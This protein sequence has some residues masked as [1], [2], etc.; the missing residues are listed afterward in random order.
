MK[1]VKY[2]F[3]IIIIAVVLVYGSIYRVNQTDQA[4]VLE[5]GKFSKVVNNI[6]K[7]EPGLHFKRPFFLQDVYTYDKRLLHFDAK[8]Q[9]F[10]ASSGDSTERDE[11][12]ERVDSNKSK[13]IVDAY[14][15]YRIVDVLKYYQRIKYE[16]VLRDTLDRILLDSL[17]K[18]VGR[19]P[20][21]SLLDEK[22]VA[23]ISEVKTQVNKEMGEYG[24]DVVDVRIK[25]A[26]L[27]DQN[28]DR[29]I[30]RMQA[31][32]EKE[33]RE[34]RAEGAEQ[35]QVIIA[36]SNK[37]KTVIV[38]EA[39]KKAQITK[40]EADAKATSIY[41]NAYSKDADFFEFTRTL[42]SYRKIIGQSD[43]KLVLSP[44]SKLLKYLDR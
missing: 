35:A 8:P 9:E 17:G 18:V 26:D 39:E 43:T 29:V 42:E 1:K 13:I 24:I 4:L 16:D 37:D 19:Y 40:G 11:E 10:I 41:N 15:K 25:R 2:I 27:P 5:F 22:R 6:G 33:A 28:Y 31:E 20:L 32:R 34:F 7:E 38:A 44:D 21:D 12:G 3:P 30:K 23:I 36:T 14:A